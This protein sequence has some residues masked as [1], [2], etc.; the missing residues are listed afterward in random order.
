MCLFKKSEEFSC[1]MPA[2]QVSL[3]CWRDLQTDHSLDVS[4]CLPAPPSQTQHGRARWATLC[5]QCARA[6]SSRKFSSYNTIAGQ[7]HPPWYPCA[8]P[9][10]PWE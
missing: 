2:F 4:P 3:Q 6:T 9:R 5:P 7:Q 10:L 8:P 1:I